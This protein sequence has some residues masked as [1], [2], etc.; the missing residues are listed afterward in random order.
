MQ[1]RLFS[2]ILAASAIA[3]SSITTISQPSNAQTNTYFCGNSKDGVPTTFART[4][5]GDKIA[6][7]RWERKRKIGGYTPQERCQ[8]VS[9]RFQS[10]SEDGVLNYL[11]TDI[12]NSQKVLCAAKRYGESC[13]HLLLTLVQ[14]DA[15]KADDDASKAIENLRLLGFGAAGPLIQSSDGSPRTFIDMYK[16]LREAP[17]EK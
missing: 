4:A 16:L 5:A 3:L 17:R 10:A 7:I 14:D 15:S 12:K 13:S 2:S 1:H 11:T 6:V 9:R 8:E